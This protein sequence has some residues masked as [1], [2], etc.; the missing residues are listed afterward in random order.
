MALFNVLFDIAA[1]TAKFEASMSRVERRLDQTAKFVNRIGQ[2]SVAGFSVVGIARFVGGVIEA[3]DALAKAAQ[4]SGTAVKAFS[5]LA[6]AME[7]A[8]IPADALST[9]LRK[10]QQEIANAGNGNKSA[11]QSFTQLGISFENIR[12]LSPDRQFE[13]IA[14]ALSRIQD[15][16]ERTRLAVELFGRAGQDLL[17]AF[18][19]GAA[20]IRAAREEAQK[21]GRVLD[22]EGAKKIQE[23][24]DAMKRLTLSA[25]GLGRELVIKLAPSITTAAVALRQL[26]GGKTENEQLAQDIRELD[27]ILANLANRTDKEAEAFRKDIL[28]QRQLLREQQFIAEAGIGRGIRGGGGKFAQNATAAEESAVTAVVKKAAEDRLEVRVTAQRIEQGAMEQFYE[29]LENSTRTSTEEQIAA[30][31]EFKSKLNILFRDGLID[32]STYAARAGEQ[33][34]A[35]LQP[36]EVSSRKIVL[37]VQKGTTQMSIFAQRAAENMQDAF[38]DFLFDPFDRGLKGM[39]RGFIDVIRRMVAEA[40]AA[41]IF[42]FLKGSGGGGGIG[43][44]LG[45]LLGGLFK[46]E[47]GPVTGGR[48]YIVGERGPELFVPGMSGGIVPNESL[49]AAGGVSISIVNTIDARGSSISRAELNAALNQSSD[50][51][52]ARVRDLVSRG[53]L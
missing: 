19:Q 5:E 34:D 33:V 53:R 42:D 37:E 28:A 17:P 15:P 16:A 3:N 2:A 39:L 11:L 7:L 44:F 52:V 31:E 6:Y 13:E 26:L 35:I 9:A 4:K 29:E 46:A 45:G 43:G 1:K 50:V 10:M 48:P 20:G 24:D 27:L 12:R 22:E 41:R 25:Q 18:E 40:A 32:S 36:I 49:S 23:A 8:D 51:T 47:G 14:D 21:L 30:F 38:A